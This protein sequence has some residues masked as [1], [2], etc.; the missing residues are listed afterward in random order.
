M[1]I[2]FTIQKKF[3]NYAYVTGDFIIGFKVILKKCLSTTNFN[4]NI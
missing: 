4:I 3:A 1:N 2:S